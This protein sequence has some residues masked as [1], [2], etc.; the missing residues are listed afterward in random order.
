MRFN[1]S[2]L[3]LVKSIFG[4]GF[5][6]ILIR[7]VSFQLAAPDD[8]KLS[9]ISSSQYS[10]GLRLSS[11]RGDITDRSGNKLAVSIESGS[12]FANPLKFRPTAAQMEALSK[13][14]DISTARLSAISKRKSHFVWIKRK[15]SA[16]EVR[17]VQ[18]LK[19]DGL[20]FT[21]EPHRLYPAGSL[22]ATILGAVNIDSLGIAGVEL[23]FNRELQGTERRV[24]VTRD[25]LGRLILSDRN[26]SEPT[27][28]GYHFELTIDR[29]IQEIAEEALKAG[30]QNASAKGGSVIVGDP[31]DG[32]ILA[33]ADYPSFNPN[34]RNRKIEDMRNRALSDTFE[35][36]SVIKP[37]V[38]A[39]AIDSGITNLHAHH[40]CNN[41]IGDAGG[42]R[43][44]DAHPPKE[45]FLTTLETIVHSS[46]VCTFEIA[47]L[48]GKDAV[49]KALRK[50]GVGE[51][52]SRMDFPGQSFGSLSSSAGWLP[53]RFANVAFGQGMTT[54][55]LELMQ[56][57]ST[58]ANDGVL[59]QPFL[60]RRVLSPE[61][62]LI[63]SAQRKTLRRVF[64]R[65]TAAKMKTA[66]MAVVEEGATK[67]KLERHTSAGKTG[68]SQKIDPLTKSYSRSKHFAVFAGFAPA[69]IAR[70]V[71]IVNIDEPGKTPHYG[72]LWAAP[73]FKQIADASL[74]YL[75]VSPDLAKVRDIARQ[76]NP[77]RVLE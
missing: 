74:K 71:I 19:I 30:I 28:S 55:V 63:F 32:S 8:E 18:E 61:G 4:I 46:N 1:S 52:L 21:Y 44:G 15:L 12:L 56:F 67:A 35:P 24:D 2:R 37:I 75:N 42:V 33:I 68:T 9:R 25:A 11:T 16:R 6:I 31:N 7:L 48:M 45:R 43:F 40:D 54:S 22:G 20:D 10:K 58:F 69:K 29:A 62:A 36:G 26:N 5:L 23:Q 73:V 34:N 60:V 47:K 66:L 38:I 76:E 3:T 27:R 17:K 57:Y 59:M 77:V 70:L 65:E 50:A 64:S 49:E 72:A 53:I 39:G 41:G 14:L 13:I 51:K